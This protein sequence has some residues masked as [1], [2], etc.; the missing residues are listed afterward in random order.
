MR[1]S[2]T[3]AA[4]A[5]GTG[6]GVGMI[7]ISGPRALLIADT[8]FTPANTA[9]SAREMRG[10][11]G[12]FGH[13]HDAAGILDEAVLFVY[14]APHSYTGE[15]TAEI[16]CHGGPFVLRKVLEAAV[17]AG[18]RLAQPGEYTRRAMLN[19]KMTLTEAESVVD[20]IAAQNT[21]SLRAAL[22][23]MDGALYRAVQ[24]AADTLTDTCA[25]IA[26]WIDYP[27]EDVEEV[28]TPE[29]R[30]QLYAVAESLTGLRQSYNQGRLIREGISTAII[31]STNVGKST[32]MN[33]LS[34]HERSIVTAIPGTTRDVVEETVRVGELMLNLKDTAGLRDSDDPVEQIG[35]ERSRVALEQ[36]D[37]ILAVFDGSLPLSAAER[38]WLPLLR[39]KC[40]LAIYNKSDLPQGLSDKDRSEILSCVRGE[41]S[42]SAAQGE[43]MP[44]LEAAVM[45]AVGLES[46]DPTAAMV[47]NVRQLGCITQAERSM[48]EAL[49]ALQAGETLDAVS[50]CLEEAADALLTLSGRRAGAD[51]VDKVFEQFCVG[52]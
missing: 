34:G 32:L 26:A 4:I 47:A 19:G 14:R 42:L 27:E 31:G 35:V 12:A 43:G 45:A 7:R 3:I 38:E 16:T 49:E 46:F 11:T 2:G 44:E 1:E 37:L 51:V 17:D 50:V 22:G 18:A 39:G 6:G 25:H 9:K 8:I 10:Y 36:C 24:A 30:A 21:Q 29:L 52:K 13:A 33:L 15:D 20:I 5:T 23:A 28:A 48:R 41:V 40:A